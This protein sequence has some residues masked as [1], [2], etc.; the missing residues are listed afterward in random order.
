MCIGSE[1]GCRPLNCCASELRLCIGWSGLA[2]QSLTT[3]VPPLHRRVK[4][5]RGEQSEEQDL[6]PVAPEVEHRVGR[7][8]GCVGVC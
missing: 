8:A 1:R 2:E 3:A 5:T 7:N 6:V 4:M